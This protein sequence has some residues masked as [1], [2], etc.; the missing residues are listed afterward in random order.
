[1]AGGEAGEK[2]SPVLCG[3]PHK[4]GEGDISVGPNL[5][6]GQRG[7]PV[8]KT[9]LVKAGTSCRVPIAGRYGDAR[10]PRW[11]VRAARNGSAPEVRTY[12]EHADSGAMP[13]GPGS[14]CVSREPRAT[15]GAGRLYAPPERLAD[16]SRPG[17]GM[18]TRALSVYIGEFGVRARLAAALVTE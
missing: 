4:T 13:A 16:Y 3:V 17:R 18:A 2:C 5:R 7:V 8:A 9:D 6:D 11:R 14:L 15:P 10:S 1:M 12:G